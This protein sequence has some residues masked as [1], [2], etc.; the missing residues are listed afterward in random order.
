MWIS[1]TLWGFISAHIYMYLSRG[2][3]NSVRCGNVFVQIQGCTLPHLTWCTYQQWLMQPFN[4]AAPSCMAYIGQFRNIQIWSGT[5]GCP[6][7]SFQR[8]SKRPLTPFERR[9]E[10]LSYARD[11][12]AMVLVCTVE[13][14]MTQNLVAG[15]T[16]GLTSTWNGD[17][18]EWNTSID[19]G[20]KVDGKHWT[21]QYVV[22]LS[23]VWEGIKDFASKVA[24]TSSSVSD[25]V[26]GRRFW[27]PWLCPVRKSSDRNQ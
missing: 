4:S 15:W 27:G 25:L 16:Y 20:W 13:V 8:F 7:Q 23:H 26:S 2:R 17:K 3:E 12:R 19:K 21:L 11:A 1:V 9:W 10:T 18:A 5:W 22:L 24:L 6:S 14:S